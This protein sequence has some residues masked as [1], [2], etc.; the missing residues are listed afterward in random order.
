MVHSLSHCAPSP[1]CTAESVHR[2][3]HRY[4]A[5]GLL[6]H[7]TWEPTLR[8]P[9]RWKRNAVP[10]LVCVQL[11]MFNETFVARR[12]IDYACR[13]EYPRDRIEVQCLDD[14]TD[15][16]TREVVDEGI[17]YWREQGMKIDAVRRTNRQGY[18]AG[19]MHEVHDAIEAEFIA[20][21]DADFLP[22]PDFLLRCIPVFQDRNVGFVQGR[23]TYLNATESLFCRWEPPAG[24]QS[25]RTLTLVPGRPQVPGDLLERAHQVRA[26]RALQHRQL[27]QFQRHRRRMAKEVHG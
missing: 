25:R 5:M 1:R 2:V 27:L 10:P 24:P 21:F 17:A 3:W 23:W 4:K 19:A 14:S 13:M 22:E 6:Q 15:P 20:I 8:Y 9:R 7:D 26:V 18:K 16:E 12:V 11:P